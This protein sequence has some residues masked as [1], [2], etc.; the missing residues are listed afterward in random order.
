MTPG[1]QSLSG[2]IYADT[3]YKA[4]SGREL[5]F[6]ALRLTRVFIDSKRKDSEHQGLA[7]CSGVAFI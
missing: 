7:G 1:N 3:V 6:F 4:V 5:L 2:A